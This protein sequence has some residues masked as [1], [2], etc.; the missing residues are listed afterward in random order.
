MFIQ[1]MLRVHKYILKFNSSTHTHTLTYTTVRQKTK[2]I[3]GFLQDD[4]RLRGMT[5]S[6]APGLSLAAVVV[7]VVLIMMKIREA[8][9]RATMITVLQNLS[10]IIRMKMTS[11]LN[12][13]YTYTY[14]HTHTQ[15][16]HPLTHTNTHTHSQNTVPR[17]HHPL[18]I[19]LSLVLPLVQTR[20]LVDNHPS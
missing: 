1:C 13:L 14:T 9:L 3:I 17:R 10:V 12:G 7:V 11:K 19:L 16:T 4:E 6:L 15:H 20:R 2:E 5:Q 18:A 8:Q